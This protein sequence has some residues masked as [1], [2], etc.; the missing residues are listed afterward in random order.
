[1]L[2]SLASTM[3]HH[4][5]FSCDRLAEAQADPCY[6]A[7]ILYLVCTDNFSK[8]CVFPMPDFAG[9]P[10][11]AHPRSSRRILLKRRRWNERVIIVI[12]EQYG[13]SGCLSMILK[14]D[15][16]TCWC[17]FPEQTQTPRK[18]SVNRVL[19]M[20]AA[21]VK[22]EK[23]GTIIVDE[24]SQTSADN[25]WALG[26]VTNRLNLTPVAIMEGM[27]FAATAF[28][29]TP[30]KPIHERVHASNPFARFCH[31]GGH[32]LRRNCLNAATSLSCCF[33]TRKSVTSL[34]CVL[35]YRH[36]QLSAMLWAWPWPWLC[37]D[38]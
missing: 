27:A 12:W 22:T 37:Y 15:P 24:Y 14:L 33:G 2:H 9:V 29:G 35:E 4:W 13:K 30:T 28:G 23:D 36:V 32:G 25:I 19:L 31:D 21:G 18:L 38:T 11:S 26:D 10:T 5:R 3:H 17:M 20:Q 1:M 6:F 34:A 7:R 16:W 8:K